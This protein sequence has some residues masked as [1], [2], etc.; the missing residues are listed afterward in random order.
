MP[1]IIQALIVVAGLALWLM[2]L[3]RKR[4]E[5]RTRTVQSIDHR[6]RWGVLLEAAGYTILWQSDFW[7]RTPELWRAALSIT[8]L[9]A[10]VMISFQAASALGSQLR[11][12]ASLSTDHQLIRTGPYRYVRHPVYLS[13]LCLMIGTGLMIASWPL[14]LAGLIVFLCGT[15]IRVRIEDALLAARFGP[16]FDSYRRSVSAYVPGL[17]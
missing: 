11:I 12:D 5:N 15:E 10:A 7:N 16:E 1:P 9:A 6:A 8:L 2:P 4:S 17:R 3:L 14:M 13:F